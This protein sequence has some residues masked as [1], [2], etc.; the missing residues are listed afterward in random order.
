[1]IYDFHNLDRHY[2][3]Q[4]ERYNQLWEDLKYCKECDKELKDA[5]DYCSQACFE[6]SLI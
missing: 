2:D 6:A 3:E 4:F 1:M 5:K